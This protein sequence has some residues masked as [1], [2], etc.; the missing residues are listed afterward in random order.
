MCK[1]CGNRDGVLGEAAV[2]WDGVGG[3]GVDRWKLVG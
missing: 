2:G 1:R 3:V